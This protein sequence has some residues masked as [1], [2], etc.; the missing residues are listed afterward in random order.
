M[1]KNS[2]HLTNISKTALVL[3]GGFAKAA[4]WHA[5]VILGLEEKG[6]QIKSKPLQNK[7]NTISTIVGS[8]AG[9]LIGSMLA[10]GYSAFDLIEAHLPPYNGKIPPLKYKDI[11][12]IGFEPKINPLSL[13]KLN[14]KIELNDI[15]IKL[16]SRSGFFSTEGIRKYLINN[17]I[18]NNNFS[19][20]DIDFFVTATQLDHS[21]KCVF[22]KYK[23]PNPKHDSTTHYYINFPVDLTISASMSVPILYQ[24]VKIKNP[25]TNEF[26]Y[27]LDG[28]IRDTLSTH[29]AIDN[30][31]QEIISSWIYTPYHYQKEIG[32]LFQYGMP[33]IGVQSLNLLFKKKL[34]LQEQV[35]QR[36]GIYYKP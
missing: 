28:E 34:C 15:L 12:N 3:S 35:F 30:G 14:S 11:F 1:Y 31:C 32:S 5:G 22:G 21:R 24:P 18:S 17:I 29:V 26:N 16:K 20:Y 13:I 7:E 23:Y 4:F 10:N 6:Y 27:F 36:L 33:A 9:A 2:K 25:N 19:S 8:S